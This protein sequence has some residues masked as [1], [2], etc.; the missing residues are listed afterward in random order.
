M[1]GKV[2]LTFE[3]ALDGTVQNI[4]GD[5]DVPLPDQQVIHRLLY[6]AKKTLIDEEVVSITASSD[7]YMLR[8]AASGAI[9]TGVVSAVAPEYR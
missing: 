5:S 3:I 9:F 4:R 1:S 8:I 2:L 6:A 7:K